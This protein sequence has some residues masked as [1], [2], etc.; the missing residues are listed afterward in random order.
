MNL[1]HLSVFHGVAKAGS[2]N[3][4][5]RLL[6]TSQPAI[7]R[8]LRTLEG[9]LGVTLF[10]RLPRGMRLTEA[11]RVLLDYAERIFG[12]EKAAERA[13]RELADLESGQLPIGASNTLG[14]YLLPAF[15]A[16]FH[17]RYPKVSLDLEVGNTQEIVRGVLD[18]RF[19]VG[20]VEGR[21]RDEAIEARE[22]RRDRI[23][24][25]VAPQHPLAKARTLSVRSLAESPSILREPGSGTREIVERAFARHR[26]A[27]RCGLQ[28]NSSEVLKRTAMEGG[29]VGWVSELCVVEELRSGRLVALKTPRLSL[30][31]ALYTLRLR[32]RHLNRSALVFLSGF[33]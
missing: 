23:V 12:F 31:R 7:S 2:V 17:V 16:S 24:A 27:P 11:G 3:A 28:I 20:F 6:H 8:E 33:D 15:V 18:S 26:L 14:T 19:V 1:R 30:E 10:D 9:R 25:V 21:I 32:G 5:A 29:G 13:I 22:F 4:A